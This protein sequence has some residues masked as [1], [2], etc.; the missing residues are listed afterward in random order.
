MQVCSLT[1]Q[2][3]NSGR[4]ESLKASMHLHRHQQFRE[5]LKW[6]LPCKDEN[7]E[8]DQFDNEMSYYIHAHENNL[9]TASLRIR[10]AKFGTMVD[11]CFSREMPN[12]KKLISQHRAMCFEIT[13]LVTA[14]EISDKSRK[15]ACKSLLVALRKEMEKFPDHIYLAVVSVPALRLLSR[16]GLRVDRIEK[17]VIDGD[18]A[19]SV[20][21]SLPDTQHAS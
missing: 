18:L 4:F 9:H 7:Y 3:L 2:S 8:Y 1:Y 11:G 14:P 15:A 10:H 17:S 20:V 13:R 21:I 16:C 19:C 6:S 5:R 12:T